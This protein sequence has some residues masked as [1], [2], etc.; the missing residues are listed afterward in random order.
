VTRVTRIDSKGQRS[1]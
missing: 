1:R